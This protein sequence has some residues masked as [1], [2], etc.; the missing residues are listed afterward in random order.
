MESDQYRRQSMA[1]LAGATVVVVI[2]LGA[3]FGSFLR[4][5]GSAGQSKI[6]ADQTTNAL[7]VRVGETLRPVLNLALARLIAESADNPVRVRNSEIESRPRGA[8][9]GI[10][11]GAPDQLTVTSPA[12]SS[13]LVCDAVTKAFG[14]GA[15]ELVTVTVIDGQLD[16]SDRR[17]MLD[18]Q[19]AVLLRYAD[20]VWLRRSPI[21]G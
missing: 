19:D 2:C 21:A 6:I 20:G 7:H 13:W 3:L 18:P 5:A 10:I 1:H 8:L 16:P 12:K 11:P 14:A 9:V 17:R 15:P 4:R